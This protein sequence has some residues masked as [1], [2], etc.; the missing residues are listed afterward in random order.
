MPNNPIENVGNCV[1]L[2]TYL[3]GT[4]EFQTLRITACL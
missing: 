1:I 4:H 3:Q 2:W